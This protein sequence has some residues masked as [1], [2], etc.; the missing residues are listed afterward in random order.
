[1]ALYVARTARAAL[2]L[3][4]RDP[5]AGGKLE[6][7]DPVA[8]RELHHRLSAR[9]PE[10][11]KVP[12]AGDLYALARLE[13]I[14]HLV[15]SHHLRES[16]PGAI[17]GALHRG[18]H[19]LGGEEIERLLALFGDDYSLPG[20]HESLLR[21]LLV[22]WALADNPAATAATEPLYE[23]PFRSDH[24]A[25]AL[26]RAVTSAAGP[27]RAED[28]LFARLSAPARAQPESLGAQLR[29][30]L[31][32]WGDLLGDDRGGLLRGLD[33]FAEEEKRLAPAPGPGP[34]ELP[35]F[36]DL[37][38]EP[39]SYSHDQD[40][41]PG[42]VL[43]AKNVY[44]WLDQLSRRHQRPIER[45]DQIPGEALAEVAG[46]GFT[47]L[48][49]I[50]VWERS[51]ASERIKRLCGNPEAV[52][53]AYSLKGY[54]V[55]A[56]LG[57]DEALEDLQRRASDHG[58]RLGADMV[59]NHLG[60][61]SDWLLT[62]PDR[63]LSVPECPFPAYTFGGPDLSSDP[64]IGIYLEDHYY[65][66]SDAAVVFKRV[67]RRSGEVRFVYHGNDGTTMPWNDT[68]QL[69][70]LDPETREAVI[71]TILEVA[72]RFPL[73]RF[74]AAMTLTRR[75]YQRLWFPAAGSGGAIPSRAE[76]GL[77]RER[78]AE[79]MPEEFWRE[80]V[81]RV[82]RE[83][84]G[85]LLLA[86]AFW[87][88]EGYF[89]RSLGMHRVYNSA[90][91]NMLRDRENGK[92]RR[93]IRETLAFDPRILQRYVNFLTNPD[94]R[95]AIDQFGAGDRYFG[96]C[97]LLATLPGLPMFGHGQVEGLTEKYGMEYRRSYSGE[98]PDAELVARHEREIVPLLRLRRCFA[99]VECFELYDFVK[100]DGSVDDDVI[101][102]SNGEGERRM[103][104]VF[105]NGESPS[106]GFLRR[107]APRHDR[108][109]RPLAAALGLE[110]GSDGTW[111]LHDRISGLTFLRPREALEASRLELELAPFS[112]LV[113]D[114]FDFVPYQA[115]GRHERLADRVGLGGVAD[116]E[117]AL[118][119]LDPDPVSGVLRKL[120][121]RL[122]TAR[123]RTGRGPR[124]PGAGLA[125]AVVEMAVELG[126]RAGVDRVELD[127]ALTAVD[128]VFSMYRLRGFPSSQRL[129]RLSVALATW[130]AAR[131]E[132]RIGLLAIRI[133]AWLEQTAGEDGARL[134]RLSAERMLV[135]VLEGLSVKPGRVA[136][137]VS[138]VRLAR[139]RRW[140]SDPELPGAAELRALWTRWRDD[141]ELQP[142][143]DSRRGLDELIRWRTAA[144]LCGAL[145]AS[146][147]PGPRVEETV[148]WLEAM[149]KLRR[150]AEGSG[151]LDG[152]G[153]GDRDDAAPGDSPSVQ[154]VSE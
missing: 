20:D 151:Y 21:E 4:S 87:L 75:H 39:E 150:L 15:I 92:Y 18:Q 30:I 144:A 50:G 34:V 152:D 19:A 114:R 13:E 146:D 99:G 89:V 6:L 70:Y 86:E 138:A 88:M 135:P 98:A 32:E 123:P 112:Y 25:G 93:L 63:F 108:P 79:L 8:A 84:P 36:S 9:E 121:G 107:S 16:D 90:F 69:D 24:G 65:D 29:F 5:L 78:F 126:W 10:G 40:W 42:V 23:G 141:P 105:N 61:D 59:P 2:G 62:A 11:A 81:D 145:T 130:L 116:L 17:E 46:W 80:V 127:R 96:A 119:D 111:T 115:G 85:T 91:M 133:L 72:K 147:E 48:W 43:L 149:A 118:A 140:S 74:D 132:R 139:S 95:T 148:G 97:V 49:L 73:I 38:E 1:M 55:A 124:D 3:E 120:L 45:L 109:G 35:A 7:P 28:G 44:V 129:R 22:W 82:A 53:S 122:P 41:M 100:P 71:E 52:A 137:T 27:A 26:R 37:D 128:D 33:L 134:R 68:A 136:R 76:H 77:D 113:L 104:V 31:E 12:S 66:R 60:L 51:A 131:P 125:D 153:D 142:F 110:A 83:A 57:G 67:D 101:A 54:S 58:I 117:R 143:L 47:G 94:E 56:A 106:T 103:L 154:T 14:S 64:A 102:Y